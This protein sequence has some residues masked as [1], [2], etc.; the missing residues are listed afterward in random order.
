MACNGKTGDEPRALPWAGMK[1]AVGLKTAGGPTLLRPHAATGT[2]DLASSCEACLA[3]NPSGIGQECPRS[4]ESK[5]RTLNAQLRIG[6]G[7]I[8]AFSL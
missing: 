1:Q 5:M 4:E 2:Y 6:M 8:L 3:A 7:V